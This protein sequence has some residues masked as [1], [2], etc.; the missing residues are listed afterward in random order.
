MA[1]IILIS[2]IK[3]YKERGGAGGVVTLPTTVLTTLEMTTTIIMNLDLDATLL[4]AHFKAHLTS[5][6]LIFRYSD[7][8]SIFK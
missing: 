7:V 8:I 1:S 5:N 4:G 3:M 6:S 2:I